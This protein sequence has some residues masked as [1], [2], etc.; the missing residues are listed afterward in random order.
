MMGAVVGYR[1]AKGN[2]VLPPMAFFAGG[3]LIA[4]GKRI[5]KNP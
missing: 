2:P 1:V 5:F 4:L 3:A